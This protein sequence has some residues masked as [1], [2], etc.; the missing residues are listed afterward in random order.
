MNIGCEKL[1]KIG[2]VANQT[3][4]SIQTLR[5]YD[6]LG[7]LSPVVIRTLSGYRL[8]KPEV[9]NRLQF[10]KKIQTL[11]LTLQEIQVIL[12]LHD[13]GQIPCGKIKQ[14]LNKQLDKIEA[15]INNLNSLKFK[16]KK[17]ILDWQELTTIDQESQII[18]PNIK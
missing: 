8:F 10:I 3:G 13:A 18:C 16:L 7:L 5:Y 15:Q 6:Q 14:Y 9:I 11:G 17:T 12:N 2:E 1:L 4:L